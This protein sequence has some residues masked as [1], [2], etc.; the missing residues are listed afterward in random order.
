MAK[1]M[2]ELAPALGSPAAEAPDEPARAEV[3]TAASDA[4]EALATAPLVVEASQPRRRDSGSGQWRVVEAGADPIPRT[5]GPSASATADGPPILGALLDRWSA[6]VSPEEP[7]VVAATGALV[8]SIRGAV[9]CRVGTLRALRG[10]A[11]RE[12]VLRRTRRSGDEALG[13]DDPILRLHGDL[14]A[15]L[16]PRP[17]EHFQAL[18]IEDDVVFFVERFVQAFDDRVSFES[19]RL[20]TGAAEGERQ[21]L[22]QFRGT[23]SVVLRVPRTPTAVPVQAGQDIRVWP[24]SLLGWTG[25]LFPVEFAGDGPGRPDPGG[26][27]ALR[28]DGA[29]LLV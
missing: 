18:R 4:L 6:R 3:R 23:G 2:D 11:E 21:P 15:M 28:G 17:G 26:A 10:R 1:R 19:G 25:R 9:H 7:L 16:V 8:V 24:E 22:V 5:A 12:R 27:I 20:P 13:G 29:L 14:L